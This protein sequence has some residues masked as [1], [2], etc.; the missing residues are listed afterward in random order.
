ML[1][2][3]EMQIQSI[4]IPPEDFREALRLMWFFLPEHEP[5]DPH[6]TKAKDIKRNKEWHKACELYHKYISEMDL[7]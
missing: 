3:L 2:P 6:S 1:H 7:L 4:P 5:C